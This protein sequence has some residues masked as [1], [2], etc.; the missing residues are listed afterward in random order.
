M[1]RERASERR[2]LPARL[3]AAAAAAQAF[4]YGAVLHGDCRA[5]DHSC[6]HCRLRQAPNWLS[7][8]GRGCWAALELTIEARH[9][10]WC[11]RAVPLRRCSH[12]ERAPSSNGTALWHQLSVRQQGSGRCSQ[13]T[14]SGRPFG[15]KKRLHGKCRAG[16]R[17]DCD[18]QAAPLSLRRSE[19]FIDCV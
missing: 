6:S 18:L 15:A 2:P 12:S 3:P 11:A 7:S 16:D 19:Q 14:T 5:C 9:C 4:G 1:A 17:Q 10:C 8:S 13:I